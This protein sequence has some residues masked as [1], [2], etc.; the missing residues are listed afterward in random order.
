[1]EETSRTSGSHI[2][3]GTES[4]L[5]ESNRVEGTKVFDPSGKDIGGIKRLV[6]EKRSGRVVYAI[7]QFGGFLGLGGNEYAIPWNKLTYD[8]QLGGFRTDITE[9]Q[10]RGAPSFRSGDWDADKDRHNERALFDYYG[11]TYYWE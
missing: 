5:I 6:I 3:T 1:M 8:T 11:S 4:S 9:D 10:L 7:A 2:Q